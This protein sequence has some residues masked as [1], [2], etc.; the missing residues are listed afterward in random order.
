LVSLS[1]CATILEVVI[2]IGDKGVVLTEAAKI[3]VMSQD[4]I[5]SVIG[6]W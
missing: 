1:D 2:F 3:G 6:D 4:I 5:K